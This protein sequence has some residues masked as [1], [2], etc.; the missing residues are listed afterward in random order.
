MWAY[1]VTK[2][3]LAQLIK[4]PLEQRKPSDGVELLDVAIPKLL[5][6]EVLIEVKS[7]ALNYNSIW[8]SLAHPV[9][10]FQLINQHI[11]RNKRDANHLQDYAIFGS[12]ASGI[13]VE[14][15]KNVSKFNEGDEVIVHC[16]VIDT[17]EEIVQSDGMLAKSQSIWGYETNY[18]AFAQYCKAKSSQLI[19]K[20][21]DLDWNIAGSYCLT[22]STAYRMLISAN[23]A[24]LRAGQNCLIWGASGG[25][26]NFAI[27]LANLVG[28]NPIAVVSSDQ[29]EQICRDL[30]SSIVINRNKNDLGNFIMA[31]GEPNYLSWRKFKQVL[32]GHNVR[33]LDVVFEHVGRET[34]GM[35]L[36]L[37][38]RGGKVVTCAASSG[39]NAT[40]DLRYLWMSLKRII[41]S[42]FANY[43]EA[44]QASELIFNGKIKPLIYS[45]E[46]IDQ[47]PKMMNLMHSCAGYGKIVFKHQ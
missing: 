45:I 19:L 15:G 2:E 21:K 28:A 37:L 12:D 6:D 29:K 43:H 14:V 36:F 38:N 3:K 34:L 7:S 31:N 41:G 16:N 23:G 40:I 26:G 27:Q 9:T 33:D 42:H 1:G 44:K 47:L 11:S 13:I 35:S 32:E 22:L 4:I 30:G 20:P 24:Q 17:E 25:L 10:P 39:Y 46:P 8:S 5:D 18:G